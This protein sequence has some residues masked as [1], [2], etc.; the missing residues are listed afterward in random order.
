[1]EFVA[2]AAGGEGYLFRRGRIIRS[3]RRRLVLVM[4]RVRAMTDALV[5]L[6]PAQL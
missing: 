3:D 6:Q 2:V 1:M 5:F 4:A